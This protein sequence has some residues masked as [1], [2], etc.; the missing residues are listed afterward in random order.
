MNHH[1]PIVQPKP[2]AGK[3]ITSAAARRKLFRRLRSQRV[4]NIGRWIRDE[5]YERAK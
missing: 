2:V 5:L 4:V 1:K 3:N